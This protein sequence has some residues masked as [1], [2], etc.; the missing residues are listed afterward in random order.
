MGNRS[1][2][3][4]TRL[5]LAL[6]A[7]LAAGCA[8][9][10]PRTQPMVQGVEPRPV[11][12]AEQAEWQE[13]CHEKDRATCNLEILEKNYGD[14]WRFNRRPERQNGPP[15]LGAGPSAGITRRSVPIV[16]WCFR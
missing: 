14:E 13:L 11:G 10:P 9:T 15:R 8:A 6:L 5:L 12:F 16:Y 3:V 2:L 7:A 4:R 1:G